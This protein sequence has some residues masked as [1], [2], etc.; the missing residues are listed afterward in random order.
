MAI[1]SMFYGIII[2]MYFFNKKKHNLPHILIQYQ[3]ENAVVTIPDG[4]V[5][6]REYQ[7]EQNEISSSL[8]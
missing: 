5:F 2:S 7:K 8:D 6:R 3:D 1:I 4:N